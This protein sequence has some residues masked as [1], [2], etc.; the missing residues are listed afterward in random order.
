MLDKN[1]NYESCFKLIDEITK[2]KELNYIGRALVWEMHVTKLLNT[3]FIEMSG[4]KE[5]V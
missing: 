5:Y 1:V 3:F 4:M 2:L